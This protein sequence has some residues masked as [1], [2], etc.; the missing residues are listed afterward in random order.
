MIKLSENVLKHSFIEENTFLKI[1]RNASVL[2][3]GSKEEFKEIIN[4]KLLLCGPVE[5]LF[6]Q[7]FSMTV[8]ELFT[9]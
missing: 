8:W 3:K 5:E 2:M 9:S 6:V 7:S 4:N 1:W